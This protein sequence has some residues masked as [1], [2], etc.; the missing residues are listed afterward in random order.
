MTATPG[1]SDIALVL[2][3]GGARASYQVGVLAA[4]AERV[5]DLQ[6]PIITGVS[7]GAINAAFIAGH[8]SPLPEAIAQL[9]GAWLRLT[10]D[11]VYRVKTVKVARW[12][13][14]LATQF[15]LR[16]LEGLRTVRGLMDMR[17]LSRFLAG[18]IDFG[19]IDAN[20]ESGRLRAVA[21]TA[22]SYTS[23]QTVTF[24]QGL[25]N[26]TMWERVQRSAVYTRLSLAHVMASS[27]IP[28]IF[29]AVRIGDAFYGDG[30]VRQTTPLS[31]AVHLGAN[32]I[33]AVS[34][35]TR[36][37]TRLVAPDAEYPTTAQVMAL[38]FNAIFLDAL[39]ADSER[40]ERLN[41]LVARIPRDQATPDMERRI[42][43]LMM[44]PSRDLGTLAEGMRP[45]LPPTFDRVVQAMG[46]TGEGSQDFL[47]YLLFDPEYTGL[48]MELGYEDTIA[49]WDRIEKFLDGTPTD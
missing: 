46:G 36:H 7:A 4:L 35:R 1:N 38:M 27:A 47:S 39:D 45:N 41:R 37:T 18:V 26:M 29:P 23:G 25:P 31:P 40:L 10:P 6:F 48:L 34:M 22:T 42:D 2:S 44:R 13:L 19:G 3:G 43:M 5:P 21:L 49:A 33:I 15:M 14:R 28:L 12:A 20:V 30:S 8:P 17:P 11:T 32:R 24:V 9:R 16:K